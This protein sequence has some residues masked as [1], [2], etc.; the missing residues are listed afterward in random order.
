[1][2]RFSVWNGTTIHPA[3]RDLQD[4]QD[5][6]LALKPEGKWSLEWLVKGAEGGTWQA[7]RRC[8]PR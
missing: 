6:I 4:I 3:Y 5:A 7:A 2:K 1:M 8:G